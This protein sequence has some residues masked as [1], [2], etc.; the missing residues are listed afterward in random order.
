VSAL[1]SRIPPDI[2]AKWILCWLLLPN[3]VIVL[4]WQV[5]AK[6]MQAFILMSGIAALIF[7]QVPSRL[8]R[9]IGAISIFVMISV[10]YVARLFGL[11]PLN[12]AVVAQFITEVR[13]LRSPEYAMAGLVLTALLILILVTTPKVERF[14]NRTQFLYAGVAIGLFALIDSSLTQVR[15]VSL[16]P[17]AAGEKADPAVKQVGLTPAGAQGRHV[18][19][20]LV[21]ALGQ[22][23]A[24]PER[25]LFE[26]DWNRPRWKQRYTVTTGSNRFAGS[27]TYGELRELCDT[28]THYGAFDFGK[29]D[30]LPKRFTRAGYETTAIH[31]FS[32]N[33]FDRKTWYPKVGFQ[34][35]VFNDDL[36]MLGVRDCQ[37]IFPGRCD[38]DVGEVIR[39]RLTQAD[40]PQF[41]Y[42]L[43]LNS[44][45]PVI[46]DE[47]LGTIQCSLG[48]AE[49]RTE[50]PVIC[51]MFKVHRA[52]ANSIDELVMSPDLPP[53]DI[54][55]VGDHRPPLF[56]RESNA[57]FSQ[58]RVPWVYLRA[59]DRPRPALIAAR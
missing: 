26:A 23:L 41:I 42:W 19:V 59:K 14:R 21:E 56:G 2:P 18:M 8:V 10:F 11:P 39:K 12:L 32:A 16:T 48:T 20:I 33:F 47:T 50:F 13:P 52:L 36:G 28:T 30:C 37:G 54:L 31:S 53:V 44:H 7:V 58:E 27:T 3:I 43:T 6:P 51:R 22:P 1:L 57:R 9:T 55:I 17:P 4:M 34:N 5:A 40:H 45:A 25:E 49:W 35:L 29:A 46:P 38:V 24:S 15:I